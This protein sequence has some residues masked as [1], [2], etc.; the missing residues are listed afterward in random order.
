MNIVWGLWVALWDKKWRS[1]LLG[2]VGWRHCLEGP[3][4]WVRIQAVWCRLR[5]HPDGVW[6]VNPS[7]Y[8]PDMHCRNCGDDLG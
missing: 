5:G 4:P 1:Y 8:E 2:R 7:G 6:W 3:K